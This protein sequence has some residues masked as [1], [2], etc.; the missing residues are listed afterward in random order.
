MRT[1]DEVMDWMIGVVEKHGAFAWPTLETVA[2]VEAFTEAIAG[3]YAAQ[4]VTASR[5]ELALAYDAPA[6]LN[7][8]QSG[9][10]IGI[11]PA[12]TINEQRTF[13]GI[14]REIAAAAERS[15]GYGEAQAA[16][17]FERLFSRRMRVEAFSPPRETARPGDPVLS[18]KS[19]LSAIPRS[20][21]VERIV[22]RAT[23]VNTSST[24]VERSSAIP[25]AMR[26][27]GWGTPAT[28]PE[29]PKPV[30]LPAPEVKRVA[31][32]VMREIDRRIIARRE[33][34]GK[35]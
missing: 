31:E 9:T 1:V 20:D 16:A 7:Y 22:P 5:V 23:A 6:Q 4:P 11:S 12:V 29:P 34:M 15:K 8:F 25:A 14:A 18:A 2:A 19:T 24:R 33:R 17:L 27:S 32:Q 13:T 28:F 21:V 35:R 26:D 3:R 10:E 30:T